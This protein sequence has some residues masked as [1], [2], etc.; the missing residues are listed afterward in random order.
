MA[1]SQSARRDR[2]RDFLRIR[3]AQLRPE[4]VGLPQ[5]GR[6][7]TTG[8][9]REEVATLAGV[10]VS[11]YTWLEQGRDINISSSVLDSIARVL[12]MTTRERDYFA[13]LAGVTPPAAD[14]PHGPLGVQVLQVLRTWQ[15]NPAYVLDRHLNF[16]ARN[17]PAREVFGHS[18]NCL[19]SFFTEPAHRARIG[20]WRDAAAELVGEL[21]AAS[22]H[23]PDAPEL[24]RLIAELTDRSEEFAEL[25]ARHE[26]QGYTQTSHA[27]TH[28]SAGELVFDHTILSIPDRPGDWLVLASPQPGTATRSRL[29]GTTDDGAQAL[30]T[31]ESAP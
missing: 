28:P 4:D 26:V 22:S 15:P 13:T 2:L 19:F 21:R 25:W 27:L 18:E 9:R 17:T 14:G 30:F 16:V 20:Q 1:T 23:S 7:R 3:R 31:G 6:R 11:W 24:N 10:G 5:G 29:W 12:R 8:L